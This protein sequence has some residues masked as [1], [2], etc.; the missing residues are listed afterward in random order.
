MTLA[1][2]LLAGGAFASFHDS[3]EAVPIAHGEHGSNLACAVVGYSTVKGEG[4]RQ[5]R[6]GIFSLLNERCPRCEY[7]TA[8]MFAGGETLA[9]IRDSYCRSPPA[10]GADGPVVFLGG[11]NDDYFWGYFSLPRLAVAGQQGGESWRGNEIPAAAASLARIGAQ[12][13]ALH[14]FMDCVHQRRSRLLFLH[15]SLVT[16]LVAGRTPERAAMLAHRRAAVE[17]AG[18][19]FVDLAQEFAPEAG[20]TWFNDYVH[21]SRVAHERVADLA[22]RL[23]MDAAPA[24]RTSAAPAPR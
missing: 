12:E 2:L 4:L 10:F 1:I 16:D 20:V 13:A 9:W 17:A 23:T 19:T 22:C 7:K 18:G 8:G 3:D 6:G 11:V 15:D 14:G 21:L 5:M 24:A